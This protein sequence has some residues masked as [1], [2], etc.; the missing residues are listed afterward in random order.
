MQNNVIIPLSHSSKGGIKMTETKGKIMVVDD[1]GIVAKDIAKKVKNLGYTVVATVAGSED[2]IEKA[3][4][5]VPDIILM[6]IKLKSKKD[7]IETADEIFQKFGIPSIYLTAYSDEGT[8]ERAKRTHPYGYIIKPFEEKELEVNLELAFHRLKLERELKNQH[9]CFTTI[10]NKY[11]EYLY[12]ADPITHEVLFV[13]Q[14]FRDLTGRTMIEG[15]CYEEFHGRKKP[16]DFCTNELIMKTGM[17]HAWEHDNPF[18]KR[19]FLITDQIIRWPDGRDVRFETA[20]DITDQ[21][22]IEKILQTTETKYKSFIEQSS[23]G[24]YVLDKQGNITYLNEKAMELTGIKMKD[25][26]SLAF[27]DFISPED[28]ELATKNLQA[29]AQGE[30][31]DSA[32]V[33]NIRRTDNEI[34]RMEVQTLPIWQDEEL[35]GFHGTIVDITQRLKFEEELKEKTEFMDAVVSNSFDGIF[36]IDENFNYKFINPASGRIMGHDPE[37]WIGKRA[38]T[39]RHPD[40][41]KQSVEA[42]FKALSGEQATC[43]VRVKH[44]SG[45]YRLLEMRYSLMMIG[46][47]PHIL[48]MV[49]DIT[50]KK[51]TE[52]ALIASEEKYRSLFEFS[53]EAIVILGMDGYIMECN[54]ATS[55]LMSLPLEEIIG[56][57]FDELG[58]LDKSQ[59]E[60]FGKRFQSMIEGKDIVS[61]EV[62]LSLSGGKSK[63]IETFPSPIKRDGE[64]YAIQMIARDITD[65]KLAEMEMRKKLMKFKLDPGKVYLSEEPMAKQSIEAFKELL[66]FGNLGTLVSRRARKDFQAKIEYSFDH[67]TISETDKE[68]HV[69]PS[70]KKIHELLSN[71]P[72]GQIIHIDCVEYLASRIGPKKTLNLVQYLKDLA[73]I[74]N[75]IV[76]LSIDPT[77]I[78]EKDLRLIEKES[79]SIIPSDSLIKLPDK[80]MNTI[81]Y[82]DSLNNEG[83][84]PSYS[85][86]GD[87]FELSK[88]TMRVRIRQLEE[89]GIV[90][91]VQRGRK[92]ILELT[93]KG[94]NYLVV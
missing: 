36:V 12:V 90:N 66:M 75:F 10:F 54:Q 79:V 1:K 88:P 74:K 61:R 46:E 5:H 94:K 44:S 3:K 17:P 8:L 69:K 29:L 19:H 32:R 45:E 40:D 15:K 18:L 2:A 71:L 51:K 89:L 85:E 64:F 49:N 60:T 25:N 50:N 56:K 9:D 6:D 11:P 24:F 13:N 35:I 72:S 14:K 48:G 52:E 81:A 16:C 78:S 33:Y 26:A 21:K 77:A 73:M 76:L 23:Y 31:F 38:G 37:E 34:R 27:V 57:K 22:M 58:L 42:V 87:Y 70:Y 7:G 43:E 20:I 4:K 47:D 84:L 65:R 59:L 55:K 91:E 68:N 28:Y 86:I 80:L 62:E 41:E 53:P 82:I 92:K 63:W 67:I 39:N 93:E 83:I 30:K